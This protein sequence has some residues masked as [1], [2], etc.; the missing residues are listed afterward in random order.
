MVN[1][2]L[3][4]YK[5][6]KNLVKN[7]DKL[8]NIKLESYFQVFVL[9]WKVVKFKCCFQVR[10]SN[11][12]LSYC[13]LFPITPMPLSAIGHFQRYPVD[14]GSNQSSN[15]PRHYGEIISITAFIS[16]SSGI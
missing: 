3:W 13:S 11:T 15:V 7:L 5:Q 1:G 16:N 4:A 14:R 6:L 9:I 8:E 12:K 10:S 2:F